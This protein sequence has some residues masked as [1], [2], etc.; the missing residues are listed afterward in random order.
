MPDEY[1]Q[2]G[3]TS[4]NP[5]I[6]ISGNAIYADT[7]DAISFEVKKDSGMSPHIYFKYIKKKFSVLENMRVSNRLKKLEKLF[8][9]SI[10]DGQEALSEKFLKEI[11]RE[12]K[13]TELAAR[14]IKLFIDRDELNK[15]K[16][17]IRK[18]HISDTPF[19]KYTR[20]IPKDV[21]EKKK[22]VEKLFDDFIIYHYWDDSVKDVKKMDSEEKRN[23]R[24]P[25]LFGIIKESNRYYFIADWEDEYCDLTFDE[26]VDSLGKDE[27]D[28]TI[29]KP[30]INV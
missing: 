10:E 4:T 13:E 28:I 24:D 7:Q 15:Y 8:Y 19:K 2:F 30:K 18:G 21:L 14:G 20:I 29:S 23:M 3:G 9:K 11:A 22:K 5:Y 12:T 27:D 16:Y 17:K 25:V 1:S 26:I 6:T